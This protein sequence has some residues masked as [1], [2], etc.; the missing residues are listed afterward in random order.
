MTEV[1]AF[2]RNQSASGSFRLEIARESMTYAVSVLA[3][4][5][6]ASTIDSSKKSR[7]IIIKFI[8]LLPPWRIPRNS[9]KIIE[10]KHAQRETYIRSAE[11]PRAYT[12]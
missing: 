3:R 7:T 10:S 12:L 1:V 2:L 6:L 8:S 9:L 4:I 5:K 11:R